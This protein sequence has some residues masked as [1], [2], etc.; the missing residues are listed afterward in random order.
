[1]GWNT[2]L[3]EYNWPSREGADRQKTYDPRKDG[4]RCDI[5]PLAGQPVVP[6]APPKSGRVRLIVVG[7]GPGRVEE[8]WGLPFIG[9][10]GA[11]FNKLVEENAE[12]GG[13][14]SRAAPPVS[15]DDMF[16]TNTMMC[17]GESDRDN[18]IAAACCAPRLLKELA[19]LPREVPILALG[20]PA[21]QAIL[22]VRSILLSR[23]FVWHTKSLDKTLLR[24]AARLAERGAPGEDSKTGIA[25]ADLLTL[26]DGILRGRASIAGRTVFPA[27]HP[28]FV[29]RLETWAPILEID[30]DRA[31]RHVRGQQ[32]VL[33]DRGQYRVVSKAQN[34]HRE[35]AKL[36][37]VV[38]VDI[39][40]DGIDPLTTKLLCVGVSDGVR[41]VV[42]HP[43]AGKVRGK[44]WK[45]FQ[46]DALSWFFKN[47]RAVV[48]HNGYNFD[49]VV[50]R[51]HGVQLGG[52]NLEDTL[53]AH[54]AF[55]SHL[56]KK[57]DQVVSEYI[58]SGPW[59][60]KHGR[61]GAEEKGL[62]PHKMPAKEVCLYNCLVGDTP[63]VLADGSTRRL[64]D[65]VRRRETPEVLSWKDG[66]IV[67]RRVVGWTRQRRPNQAW[68]QIKTTGDGP[69][70][71][72]VTTPDHEVYTQRGRVEAQHVREGDRLFLPLKRFSSTERR[73][74]LGTLLG[75]SSLV[76][77]PSL[78]KKH[79][80]RVMAITGV[81]EEKRGLVQAKVAVLEAFGL[82]GSVEAGSGYKPGAEMRRYSTGMRRDLAR[83]LPLFR[84]EQGRRRLRVE[85]LDQ[86]GPIGL[87]WWFADDGCRAAKGA[88][89]AVHRY[90]DRDVERARA[91]FERR[92]GGPVTLVNGKNIALN[93]APAERFFEEIAPHLLPP[94]RYK[95]PAYREWPAY[96]NAI[97]PSSRAVTAR[98]SASAPF[99]PPTPKS[100]AAKYA[101]E[102]IWCL[103]VEETSNFFTPFGLV[104]NSGDVR[105][106]AIAWEGMQNDL[107]EEREVYE[108]DKKIS[109]ICQQMLI[110]G[111]YMDRD[112]R[113]E[114]RRAMRRRG[115]ALKAEMRKLL[116][117]ETFAPMKTADVRWAL[118]KKLKAPILDFTPTGLPATAAAQLEE[119]RKMEGRI[120]K[121]CELLLQWRVVEKVRGTYLDA[122][123]IHADG[124]VHYT[125]RPYGTVSG[126]W[127]CRFQSLPRK[128]KEMLPEDRMGEC[129]AAPPGWDYHY[130]DLSQSEM[131]AAAYISAD[132]EFIKTCEG[133]DVHA[134]NAGILFP[135]QLALGYFKKGPPC[136][137]C[138]EKRSHD[139]GQ[140]SNPIGSFGKAFRDIAKNAG[141]GILYSA[142]IDT[143]FGFLRG[144]G[145][146]VQRED[147]VAMF[148]EI[149]KK[150]AVYYD[151]CNDNIGRCR[152]GGHLRTA[153]MG[154]IRWF[155][156]H[157]KPG[158]IYNFPIQSFIA[159]LMNI[160]LIELRRR[161]PRRVK[162]GAQI[163]DAL[164]LE[165]R[166]G[167][168]SRITGELI[169]ELWAEPVRIPTNGL[170]F[171][172]PVDQKRGERLIEFR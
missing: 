29:L 119:F 147:V 79:R 104:A 46:S 43:G 132:P 25:K 153:L 157:P 138:E 159:D 67:A 24:A 68:W 32:L 88:R 71:G 81:H 63:V 156:Y 151:Y 110:D 160:R 111:I 117:A 6:S 128:T 15:R 155:G 146:D 115:L 7:E 145:F 45:P 73:A 87:A 137:Q 47:C 144:K 40:T 172:M 136:K 154:R 83:L 105:L 170:E 62:L 165:A 16:V 171:V 125:W 131:R 76:T 77:S 102:T 134:G 118:Y 140:C 17:R 69:V 114:I 112:R 82:G 44:R 5:C 57:L 92:Y 95:L 41:T 61:R 4:A 94:A 38:A 130:F 30:I 124:R 59:K 85:V 152:M 107:E 93:T 23:G 19:A 120:G 36:G 55:A 126:R 98:V 78:R 166:Q 58:D 141:F 90:P 161:L 27:L 158:D 34:I 13:N 135:E 113:T 108:H 35:L 1:M 99:T 37:G 74:I 103:T 123:P 20:R 9:P 75:D 167:K 28:A 109:E 54:H 129:Y 72:L 121:F 86:L 96:G 14:V 101:W 70:R 139:V 12:A 56:P 91:W 142:E 50:L 100:R 52:V 150:Y 133:G 162:V 97:R 11:Y 149:H 168:D 163:H 51:Q 21:A 89:F 33:R 66:E 2:S 31:F 8:R 39:E 53:L 65:I 127:A 26:K 48:M 106:T 18:A 116:K 64:K 122:I 22:G 49:Q 164:L 148:D 169:R 42:V 80:P 143:I 10:T 60:V 84:D 3:T